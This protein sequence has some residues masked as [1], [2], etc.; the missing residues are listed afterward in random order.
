M[1]LLNWLFLHQD[2]DQPQLSRQLPARH[3]TLFL[4][5]QFFVPY[6][7]VPYDNSWAAGV[8]LRTSALHLGSTEDTGS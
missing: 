2:A 6:S 3:Q 7:E 5:A 8:D 4:N 1:I